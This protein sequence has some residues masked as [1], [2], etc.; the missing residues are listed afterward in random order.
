MPAAQT[1]NSPVAAWNAWVLGVI[2]F[3]IALSAL[4]QRF[5][6]GHEWYNLILGIW[7][8]IAPW[9]LGFAAAANPA[10]DHWIVGA[11]IFLASASGF[12]VARPARVQTGDVHHPFP[13]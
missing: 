5:A 8:F 9:V 2:V 3:L 11:L 1:G 13:R 7:I 12:A 4:G 6:R 10:W